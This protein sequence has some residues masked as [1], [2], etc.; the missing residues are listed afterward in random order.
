MLE[1]DRYLATNIAIHKG[2]ALAIIDL[3][4]RLDRIDLNSQ[5]TFKIKMTGDAL[6]EMLNN[7]TGEVSEL[8][9]ITC[10]KDFHYSCYLN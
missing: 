9:K 8:S 2:M 6:I 7:L 3:S 10:P 5:E 1:K 4:T